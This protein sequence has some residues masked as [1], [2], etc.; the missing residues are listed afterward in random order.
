MELGECSIVQ[1]L[2]KLKFHVFGYF[3][4]S[5]HINPLKRPPPL[6]HLNLTL[7]AQKGHRLCCRPHLH[8]LLTHHYQYLV[9]GPATQ[10]C[11]RGSNSAP[12]EREDESFFSIF[13]SVRWLVFNLHFRAPC[14]SCRRARWSCLSLHPGRTVPF[15]SMTFRRTV[16]RSK[17]Y[18]K[19]YRIYKISR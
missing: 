14:L 18:G 7:P 5:I 11:S 17:L 2:Y 8:F 16:G 19:K 13:V 4:Y 15:T 9:V 10:G 6:A 3:T 1:Y 12:S